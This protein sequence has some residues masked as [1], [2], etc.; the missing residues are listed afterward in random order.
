MSS[1]VECGIKIK[2]DNGYNV[3]RE[4]PGTNKALNEILSIRTILH[5]IIFA[6]HTMS[7][8]YFTFKEN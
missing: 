8:L 2:Q 4:V 5:M 6:G 7:L 3:L 1:F